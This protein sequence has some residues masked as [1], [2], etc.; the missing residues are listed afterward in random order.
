MSHREILQLETILASLGYP[1]PFFDQFRIEPRFDIM[2]DILCWLVNKIDD[3]FQIKKN[4]HSAKDREIFIKTTLSHLYLK[5]PSLTSVHAKCLY[6]S[7]VG[8]LRELLKIAKYVDKCVGSINTPLT[9]NVASSNK[10]DVSQVR[11][12]CNALSG[13]AQQLNSQLEKDVDME[14]MRNTVLQNSIDLAKMSAHII[15]ETSKLKQKNVQISQELKL[16]AQESV[17]IK[18]KLENKTAELQ[19]REERLKSLQLVRPTYMD[20]YEKLAEELQV[21]YSDFVTKSKN[22]GWLEMKYNEAIKIDIDDD[23]SSNENKHTDSEIN[24]LL[25][26]NF[27]SEEENDELDLF[28]RKQETIKEEDDEEEESLF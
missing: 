13:S 6:A 9:M 27:K 1:P 25:I 5:V 28:V 15:E 26:E 8:C 23:A 24:E 2:A 22:I 20:E 17:G 18:S 14:K 4:I 12:T 21:L 7:D 19:R 16:F 10:I 11:Q 3:N